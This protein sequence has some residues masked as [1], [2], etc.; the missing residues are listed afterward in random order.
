MK[1]KTKIPFF[2][3]APKG[4]N[5]RLI[6]INKYIDELKA[7]LIEVKQQ[8]EGNFK[9]GYINSYTRFIQEAQ[10]EKQRIAMEI[11]K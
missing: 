6:Q 7:K 10:A 9:Q 8:P 11:G 2:W 3:N 5:A 4:V 1:T